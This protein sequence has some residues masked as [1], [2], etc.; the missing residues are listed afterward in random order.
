[1]FEALSVSEWKPSERIADRAG[2]VAERDLRDRDGQIEDEHAAQDA[3]TC[4]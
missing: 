1:M 2:G 3:E 4:A